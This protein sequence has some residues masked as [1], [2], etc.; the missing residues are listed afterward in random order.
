MSDVEVVSDAAGRVEA[1]LWRWHG[2]EFCGVEYSSVSAMLA[3]EE[4][5]AAA[6]G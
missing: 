3:C 1:R 5:C 2:C 6:H 4:E